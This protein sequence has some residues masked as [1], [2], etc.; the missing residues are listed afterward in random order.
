[1]TPKQKQFVS[2]YLKDFN[3]AQAAIR[4]GYSKKTARSMANRLLTKADIKQKIKQAQ[5]KVEEKSILSLEKS[6]QILSEIAIQGERDSDRISAISLACKIQGWE[7]AQK[8][9]NDITIKVVY[10]E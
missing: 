7:A 8:V 1:M 9:D 2:E 10:G 4:A 3:G 6:L 5:E